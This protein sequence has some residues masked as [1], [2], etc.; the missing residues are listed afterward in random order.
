MKID[1]RLLEIPFKVAF[2]HN[3][4]SRKVTSTLWVEISRAE[5]VGIGEGCPRSYVTGETE[6][7]CVAFI[8]SR[9]ES[10][11]KIQD[12]P[13]LLVWRESNISDI[14]KNPAAWCAIELAFLDLFAQESN[15][16]IN[17]L[18]GETFL[19][20]ELTYSAILGDSS[21]GVWEKLCDWHFENKMSNFKLKLNGD[22]I[23]DSDRIN[24]ILNKNSKSEIRV[25]ANNMWRSIEEGVAY[26]HK[27]PNNINGVEEPLHFPDWSGMNKLSQLLSCPVIFDE[28]VCSFFDLHKIEAPHNK[29]V[30]LRVSKCGGLINSIA[31]GKK[32]LELGMKVIV[33]AQVGETSALTRAGFLLSS[34]LSHKVWAHE[35]AYGK[36]LLEDDP[37]REYYQ[38]GK[39]GKVF[40]K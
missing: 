24:Y 8:S 37:F 3:S 18:I 17:E 9:G 39:E 12:Y 23:L 19:P 35:G 4:A 10:L 38:L 31:I 20:S 16:S 21:Q 25:D 34:A 14:E 26:L 22:V 32:A 5:H 40:F 2:K 28:H 7:S 36:L 1:F 13:S 33:G 30:N 27:L 6:E 11:L 29:I 15:Q